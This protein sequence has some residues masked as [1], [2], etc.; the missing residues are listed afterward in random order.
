MFYATFYELSVLDAQE[1]NYVIPTADLFDEELYD[2][3]VSIENLFYYG[4]W[5]S[6]WFNSER[7]HDMLVLSSKYPQY[8]FELQGKG[9]ESEDI[10]I[11]FYWNGVFYRWQLK[12][13]YPTVNMERLIAMKT[14]KGEK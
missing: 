4:V 9:E 13:T 14:K 2:W 7:Q 1:Q 11:E 6:H 3:P 8:I 12:V 5:N 10:W